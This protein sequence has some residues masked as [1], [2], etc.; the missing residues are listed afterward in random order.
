MQRKKSL[1]SNDFSNKFVKKSEFKLQKKGTISIGENSRI[2]GG[3][4]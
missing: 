4:S 3:G 2:Y 1:F